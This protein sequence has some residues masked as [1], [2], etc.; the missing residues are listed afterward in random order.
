MSGL[1]DVFLNQYEDCETK[2]FKRGQVLYYQNEVPRH[3]GFILKGSIAVNSMNINGDERKVALLDTNDI[4]PLECI[5]GNDKACRYIYQSFTSVEILLIPI[6]RFKEDLKDNTSLIAALLERAS[7]NLNAS[8]INIEALGQPRVRDKIIYIFR[9]LLKRYGA[10]QDNG[11]WR[12]EARFTQEDIANMIGITRETV[13]VELGKL[14]KE[15][16]I[17]SGSFHYSVNLE[18]LISSGNKEAWKDFIS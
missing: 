16:I 18:K 4:T 12:I 3:A 14:K 8:L 6:K 2:E 11:W 1:K 7:L 15:G 5:F 17:D 9:Y 13:A 10:D